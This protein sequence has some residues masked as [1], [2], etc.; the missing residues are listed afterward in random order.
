MGCSYFVARILEYRAAGLTH[1]V[2]MPDSLKYTAPPQVR[3]GFRPGVLL[4][5]T[6]PHAPFPFY[7][8]IRTCGSWE[9]NPVSPAYEAGV[10]TASPYPEIRISHHQPNANQHQGRRHNR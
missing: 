1:S 9:S 4:Y 6:I 8:R 5:R 3:V 7:E 2:V 10:E